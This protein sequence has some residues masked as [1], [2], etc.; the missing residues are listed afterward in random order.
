[1]GLGGGFWVV[2]WRKGGGFLGW[3]VESVA[4]LAFRGSRCAFS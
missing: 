1:M 4:I 3:D 2:P